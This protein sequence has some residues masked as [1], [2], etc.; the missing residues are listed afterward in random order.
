MSHNRE[1][2]SY[3]GHFVYDQIIP[4]GPTL[5]RVFTGHV[6]RKSSLPEVPVVIKTYQRGRSSSGRHQFR[7]SGRGGAGN[8]HAF[9]ASGEPAHTFDALEDLYV[10]KETFHSKL[11]QQRFIST[12]RGGAGNIRAR[13]AI[14]SCLSTISDNQSEY[15]RLLVRDASRGGWPHSS[16]RGGSGNVTIPDSQPETVLI[17]VSVT[18]L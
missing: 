16:G 7:S 17:S 13:P 2:R 18:T 11:N 8:I 5:E 9:S 14:D 4:L 6:T 15:D 1:S 12:G 10:I 3:C